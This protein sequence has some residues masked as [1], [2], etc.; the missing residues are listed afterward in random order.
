MLTTIAQQ[1]TFYRSP[2]CFFCLHNWGAADSEMMP[3]PTPTSEVNVNADELASAR[4]ADVSC[5]CRLLT[6][7]RLVNA[8]YDSYVCGREL[9]LAKLADVNEH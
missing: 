9:T 1:K 2:F 7:M 4:C 8:N 6:V 5:D 3:L